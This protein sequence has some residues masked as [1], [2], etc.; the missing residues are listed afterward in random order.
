MDES[1]I[2]S[3]S[4]KIFRTNSSVSFNS[5]IKKSDYLIKK[6]LENLKREFTIL[7]MKQNNIDPFNYCPET[8]IEKI[9]ND[10][11]D[12]SQ[13]LANSLKEIKEKLDL[14]RN[15]IIAQMYKSKEKSKLLINENE[16]SFKQLSKIINKFKEE[17]SFGLK[18]FNE[19]FTRFNLN[20]NFNHGQTSN[21]IKDLWEISSDLKFQ[22]D[23]IIKEISEMNKLRYEHTNEYL[24]LFNKINTM[25]IKDIED[26][27]T[28]PKHTFDIISTYNK[29]L[30][31]FSIQENSNMLYIYNASQGV[32]KKKISFENLGEKIK[33]FFWNSRTLQIK[34]SLYITGG[35]DTSN[36]EV[37]YVLY[38][39]DDNLTEL[40]S[41]TY[42]RWGHGLS[43]IAQNYII[44]VSGYFNKKCEY[45]DIKKKAWSNLNEI[46]YWRMDCTLF[47]SNNQF[48]YVFGG[49]NNYYKTTATN[50]SINNYVDKIEK[51]R[52]LNNGSSQ[53]LATNKW[54]ILANIKQN[55][56]FPQLKKCSMGII[57]L[58]L[59]RFYLIG[60]DTSDYNSDSF[61]DTTKA[62]IGASKVTLQNT[63]LEIKINRIGGCE[64]EFQSHILE[65]PTSFNLSKTF[66]KIDT[67]EYGCFSSNNR[68]CQIK[69][70]N[71][72]IIESKF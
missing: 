37:R 68:F 32:T 41:M 5:G 52:I 34:N 12:D 10:F 63:I 27:E 1:S 38:Y 19:F 57:T 6:D 54:E 35:H 65:N 67:F 3:S 7:E 30:N 22:L 48:I 31:V 64:V 47:F 15:K 56:S 25:L 26:L 14:R 17:Y 40:K 39:Y 8:L 55:L 43:Y 70:K 44:V 72:E 20:D 11:M 2:V 69:I 62:G 60:G 46:N 36:N 58:S 53:I 9:E 45:Y 42:P 28:K 23:K 50:N 49:W 66:Q 71:Q 18:I 4:N 24:N 29:E 33:S 13:A 51:L 21:Q 61:E 59:D 16:E